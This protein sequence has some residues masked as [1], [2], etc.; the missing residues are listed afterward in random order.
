MKEKQP[1]IFLIC[2]IQVT[3][4]PM[5][6]RTRSV[7]LRYRLGPCRF[8]TAVA[9]STN[10]ERNASLGQATDTLILRLA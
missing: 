6:D 4:Y 10:R 5:R 1:I 9:G 2:I 3:S 8:A 7:R